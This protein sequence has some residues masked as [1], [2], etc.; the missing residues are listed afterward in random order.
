M[1]RTV[2]KDAF[3]SIYAWSRDRETFKLVLFLVRVFDW[4]LT[5]CIPNIVG[6]ILGVLR[7]HNLRR[8]PIFL[9][10]HARC[11]RKAAV[12]DINFKKSKKLRLQMLLFSCLKFV[13]SWVRCAV[14]ILEDFTEEN[15]RKSQIKS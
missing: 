11:G 8:L 4:S 15:S 7:K 13:S 3:S 6:M 2:T 12:K 10:S 1:L 14:K 5:R 9:R